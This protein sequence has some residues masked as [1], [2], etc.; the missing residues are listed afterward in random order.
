MSQTL[1]NRV[2]KEIVTE[3]FQIKIFETLLLT[4]FNDCYSA[5][6][7]MFYKLKIEKDGSTEVGLRPGLKW[8][9]FSRF[10]LKMF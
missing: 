8:S 3:Y 10:I 7:G 1:L 5:K 2:A 4:T 6:N 9:V